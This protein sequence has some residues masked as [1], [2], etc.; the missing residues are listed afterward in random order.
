MK[1]LY[2]ALLPVL[3]VMSACNKDI[4]KYADE[5]RVYFYERITGTFS[6][7]AEVKSFSFVLLPATVTQDTILV[8]AK[9]MGLT[10]KA[11]R[12]FRA[13]ADT[14][15]AATVDT[16]YKILDGVIP[17]DS[18]LGYLPVVVYR[19]PELKTITKKLNLKIVDGGDFKTGAVSEIRIQL[20]WNDNL[21]KP[22]NW[23]T[24]PGLVTY[25]GVYST[26]KYRFIID[27]LGMSEFPIA[28]SNVYVPGQLSHPNML[29]KK[30]I[31]KDALTL[32]N[33]T[34]TPVLTDENGLV[35]TFP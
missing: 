25:F 23:D 31:L 18:L 19:K 10:T 26:V 5:P 13:V 27:V 14:G 8:A 28:T 20:L 35:V 9:I 16:D 30:A 4:S 24:R 34:H 6:T 1:L 29:D 21:I 22:A 33:S 17:A 32:Y 11:E 2:T 7:K 15:S 12:S 3:L